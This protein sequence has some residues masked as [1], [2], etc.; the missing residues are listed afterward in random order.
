MV[1]VLSV[2]IRVLVTEKTWYFLIFKEIYH[3]SFLTLCNKLTTNLGLKTVGIDFLIVLQA[4]SPKS[5]ALG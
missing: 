2:S 3:I 1:L 5:V 4:R